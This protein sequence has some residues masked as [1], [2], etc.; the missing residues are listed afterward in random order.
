MKKIQVV[1][2]LLAIIFIGITI[3]IETNNIV[4]FDNAIYN[5]I[6]SFRN[7]GFDFFFKTITKLG[8]TM[9]VLCELCILML[10][11]KEEDCY[12]LGI[13]TI[14]TVL[15]NQVLKF[16]IRRPRPNH[17]RLIKQGGYSFPSGHAMIAISLYGFL[18]YVVHK[19]VKNK[20]KRITLEI[21]LIFII[22]G[23]GLS[24]IYVGVHYPSDIMGGYILAIMIQ[25]ATITIYNNR[26]RGNKNDKND[27]L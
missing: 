3:L 23:I 17:L 13:G 24:R 14:T 20:W 6:Y 8:N 4:E 1:I 19:R 10:S 9:I 22:I 15:T 12:K 11:L 27:C 5:F 26:F 7:D 16:I 25:L 21:L 18:L 2:G